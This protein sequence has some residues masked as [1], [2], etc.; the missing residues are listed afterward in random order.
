[1]SDFWGSLTE[2]ERRQIRE[3]RAAAKERQMRADGD[4]Y[5]EW[6]SHEDGDPRNNDP[7]NLAI[8]SRHDSTEGDQDHA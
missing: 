7:S 1:M 6:V 5:G 4:G 2:A 3:V 8:T